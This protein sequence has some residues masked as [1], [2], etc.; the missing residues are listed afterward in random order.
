[1][2]FFCTRFSGAA[3]GLNLKLYMW[4]EVNARLF[5][6]EKVVNK[7]RKIKVQLLQ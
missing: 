6:F 4:Y 7:L 2:Q 5:S 3:K 1:M